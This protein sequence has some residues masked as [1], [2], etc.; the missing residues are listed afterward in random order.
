MQQERTQFIKHKLPCHKCS[1]S[2]AVSLNENG[3][4]KCF[5]C[6]TFFTD[7]DNESTGKVIEMTSKPKPDNTF[8][9]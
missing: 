5:S 2:D 3:S 7:Y 9:T 1:S 6:N 8:L 4:A